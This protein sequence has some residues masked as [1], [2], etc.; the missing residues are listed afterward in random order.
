[1]S[2]ARDIVAPS[3][4]PPVLAFSANLPPVIHQSLSSDS[5]HPSAK[6]SVVNHS[7]SC[8]PTD[9]TIAQFTTVVRKALSLPSRFVLPARFATM[10]SPAKKLRLDPAVYSSKWYP[11]NNHLPLKWFT[12]YLDD[13]NKPFYQLQ[14]LREHQHARLAEANRLLPGSSSQP[15]VAYVL[16]RDFRLADNPALYHA[17]ELAAA[18]EAPLVVVYPYSLE[19]LQAHGTSAW[20][21]LLQFDL[22]QLLSRAFSAKNV[23][24][25]VLNVPEKNKLD[26]LLVSFLASNNVGYVFANI[27]YEVDEL[28]Q[29]I[30]LAS[31]SK[32]QFFCFHHQCV[33]EPGKLATQKGTQYSVFTPWYRSWN[34]YVKANKNIL[35]PL[36]EPDFAN[37]PSFDLSR[38]SKP[39]YQLPEFPWQFKGEDYYNEHYRVTDL[40]QPLEHFRDAIPTILDYENVKLDV[41][42]PTSSM[43]HYL[44]VGAITTRILIEEL[45]KAK[46]IKTIDSGNS[47]AVSYVRQLAWRDFYRHILC[48]WPHVCM[49]RPFQLDYLD[50]KWEQL[51]E[52]ALS[53]WC[54]GKTGFPIV[55]ALMRQ[56]K[57][58]GYMNNRSRM[59]VASFLSKNLLLDWRLGEAHFMENL[60]DGDF[61]S[62]NGGWGF[63][64]S[65]GVDPQ[66]YFRVFNPYLQSEK[67]DKEGT[68]IKK[69]VPEL[70]DIEGKSIHNPYGSKISAN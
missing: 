52:T 66:P 13:A 40:N 4:H 36:P 35:H 48:N 61:A 26:S 15:A 23:P 59:I 63:C 12:K 24:L 1:M 49:N 29:H 56:L 3:N 17:S 14:A 9:H 53:K 54:E 31:C 64:A 20:S 62:N 30:A 60:I 58:T 69:W 50:V 55:D 67:F 39:E 57:Q 32:F 2:R 25:V 10:P 7:P 37:Q 68:F 70:K 34:A 8:S 44:A 19:S 16:T 28:R 42:K 18:L 46:A 27:E 47:N 6:H 65:V 11:H 22:L 21:L 33:V 38:Y 51:D 5:L 41:N 45:H 43:S